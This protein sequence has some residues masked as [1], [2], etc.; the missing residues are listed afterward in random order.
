MERVSFSLSLHHSVQE[1]EDQ[2]SIVG[3]LLKWSPKLLLGQAQARS[4]E[5]HSHLPRGWTGPNTWAVFGCFLRRVSR[6]LDWEG[7]RWDTD[8][9]PCDMLA[10]QAVPQFQYMQ[11]YLVHK[12]AVRKESYDRALGARDSGEKNR[13]RNN[14]QEVKMTVRICYLHRAERWLRTNA[15]LSIGIPMRFT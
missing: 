2:S 6:E 13:K 5:F 1:R 3:S 14:Y 9:C 15:I 12:L 11:F 10:F 4:L 8:R 7:N